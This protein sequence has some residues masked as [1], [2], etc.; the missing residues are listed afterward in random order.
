MGIPPPAFLT[1]LIALTAVALALTVVR[2]RRVERALRAVAAELGMNYAADDRFRLA[3]RVAPLLGC[4]GAATV[5]VY[6]LLY[7][8]HAQG[9]RYL[10]AVDYTAGTVRMKKRRCAVAMLVE[11][12]GAPDELTV[13]KIRGDVGA[14]YRALAQGGSPPDV[15]RT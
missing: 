4:P 15:S 10:F 6:D 3:P 5:V 8:V 14:R 12:D 11:H 9:R 13:S 1:I 7:G 2:R